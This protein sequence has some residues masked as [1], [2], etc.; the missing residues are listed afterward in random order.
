MALIV[1]QPMPIR[2]P[3]G[4]V[5]LFVFPIPFW[6]GFQFESAYQLFKSFN[7]IYFYFVIPLLILAFRRLWKDKS[8]GSPAML[9]MAFVTIG[10]TLAVAGTSLETRHLGAFFAPV[11]VLALSP[12]MRLN[13]VR[14]NY[15]QL[16]YAFLGSVCL[17]HYLWLVIKVGFIVLPISLL[18]M[19]LMLST[20][21]VSKKVN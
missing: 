21:T 8:S 16:L 11:F 20:K 14:Q 13:I 6:S 3:L 1:N 17:V 9:F 2:L 15:R 12:D 5:Y 4:S 7:V 18:I 10:F 19:L